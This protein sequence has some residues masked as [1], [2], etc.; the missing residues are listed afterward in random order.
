M[1]PTLWYNLLNFDDISAVW[2]IDFSNKW[3]V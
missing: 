3:L 2:D 1:T